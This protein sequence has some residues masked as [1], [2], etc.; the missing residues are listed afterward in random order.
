MSI[1]SIEPN[2]NIVIKCSKNDKLPYKKPPTNTFSYADFIKNPNSI[3]KLKI[4]ELKPIAKQY[5]L[6]VGGTK[7][8]LLERIIQNFNRISKTIF[9]QRV[10]RGYLVRE[11]FRLRGEALKNRSICTN[12][13]DFYT[14]EPIDEI[15]FRR[16]YSYKD[17]NSFC[18]G[19][20]IESLHTFMS[21]TT[22]LCIN[23]PYN[24]EKIPENIIKQIY[25]LIYKI[26]ILFKGI[27]EMN[28]VSQQQQT[29]NSL[30]N[31][32]LQTPRNQIRENIRENI[33][34]LNRLTTPEIRALNIIRLQPIN[35]RIHELFMEID[36]LGNYTNIDWFTVLNREQYIR[37]YRLI[38][39]IWR[40]LPYDLRSKICI[41]G[42]PFLNI[43]S[44]NININDIG[45]ERIKE[46][47]VIV[48]ENMVFTGLD[49]EYRK[50]GALH[51][52]SA[53]TVVSANARIAIPWLYD[54][55]VY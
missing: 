40:R 31:R 37:L 55:I 50:I 11:S 14:L 24:R 32:P 3:K 30:L 28:I 27:L 22:K 51:V 54:T 39:N 36:Q 10:Y 48:F 49:I 38:Y 34:I 35:M 12:S 42:D 13:T 9:L 15:D 18:Y 44:S 26:R 29:R 6:L 45:Y 52:L 8:I 47:C 33:T 19:F 2:E 7:P 41:S 20:D 1:E 16:F 46:A 4:A 21:K 43:F 17:N 5:K 23:N 25:S 53:L